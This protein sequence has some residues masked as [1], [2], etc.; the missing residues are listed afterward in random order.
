MAPDP[1]EIHERLIEDLRPKLQGSIVVEQVLDHL[2]FIDAAQKELIGQK[3]KTEGNIS[4]VNV[5]I[6]AVVEKPHREGWFRAF[7]DALSNGGCKRAAEYLESNPPEP[8]EEAENDHCI[9]L[10][11]LLVPTLVDMDTEQVCV[12]CHSKELLTDDDKENVSRL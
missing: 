7:V 9:R 11:Q 4:A 3:A 8:E 1:D 2:H 12:S 6:N 5:L 10:I